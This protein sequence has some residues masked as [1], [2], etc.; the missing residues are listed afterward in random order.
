MLFDN[1]LLDCAKILMEAVFKI[2]M[3]EYPC[4]QI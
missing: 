3:Q 1:V 4:L 2:K